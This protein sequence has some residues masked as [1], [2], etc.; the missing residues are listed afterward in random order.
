MIIT[1]EIE[2]N[3]RQRLRATEGGIVG[4]AACGGISARAATKLFA[5]QNVRQLTYDAFVS[6]LSILE[7]VE[8]NRRCAN[9]EKSKGAR[10]AV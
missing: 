4:A 3:L 6:G 8:A 10:I 1:D 5:R 7:E 9:T 2:Q